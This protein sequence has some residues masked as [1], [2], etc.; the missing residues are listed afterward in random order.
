MFVSLRLDR[1]ICR[2]HEQH[3]VDAADAGQHVLDEALVA[4]NVDKPDLIVVR[5]PARESEV[6]GDTAA[7]LFRQT[8]GVHAGER[9][10]QS[11]FP[12]IN[13]AGGA[14]NAFLPRHDA[15]RRLAVNG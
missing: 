4:G 6:D 14:E 9:A 5:E 2:H 8:I 12:M 13:V 11:G 1:F 3:A 15:G 7:L 10:N